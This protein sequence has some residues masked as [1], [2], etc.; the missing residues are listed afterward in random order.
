MQQQATTS[1]DINAQQ[2]YT[3]Q[4]QDDFSARLTVIPLVCKTINLDLLRLVVESAL[5]FR[6]CVDVFLSPRGWYEKL[7][8]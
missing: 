8:L 3:R 4:K 5:V 7:F 2:K 1:G 6:V